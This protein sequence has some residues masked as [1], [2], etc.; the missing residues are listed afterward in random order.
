M[1]WCRKHAYTAC[2]CPNNSELYQQPLAEKWS[3]ALR[4]KVVI[5]I[6]D[7][8]D[9]PGRD[10]PL[11]YMQIVSAGLVEGEKFEQWDP[12][13]FKDQYSKA[14]VSVTKKG[15]ELKKGQALVP[16]LPTRPCLFLPS[17]RPL[18]FK[19]E[20][21]IL[22][23]KAIFAK[24]A[25]E[26]GPDPLFPP[27]KYKPKPAQRVKKGRV[28]ASK[29]ATGDIVTFNGLMI[30]GRMLWLDM[31]GSQVLDAISNAGLAFAVRKW[32]EL[33]ILYG[34]TASSTSL[35]TKGQPPLLVPG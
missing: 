6:F 10:K 7:I 34:P 23:N 26:L 20:N 4:G 18:P 13:A 9:V 11:G 24:L 32:M 16:Q 19:M 31:A 14:L 5:S 1:S 22:Q 17:V 15:Y 25:K 2:L 12:V 35:P 33:E 27:S 21:N 3:K 28:T 29:V 30:S 8:E